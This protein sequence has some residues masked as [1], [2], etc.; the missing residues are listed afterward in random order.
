MWKRLQPL[1]LWAVEELLRRLSD[2]VVP[3]T[4]VH[5]YPYDEPRYRAA[6]RM[7]LGENAIPA[8][9]GGVLNP[10]AGLP[11]QVSAAA[12]LIYLEPWAAAQSGQAVELAEFPRFLFE[13]N[14]GQ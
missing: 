6:L 5:F 7:Q 1:E 4:P 11:D 8:A 12:V 14:R 13:K 2:V 10:W 3:G 9:I